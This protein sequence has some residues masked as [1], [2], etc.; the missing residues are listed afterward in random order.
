MYASTGTS[1]QPGQLSHADPA[2]KPGQSG[3][4]EC[5]HGEFPQQDNGYD[6]AVF[7]LSGLRHQI[8]NEANTEF[9]SWNWDL[10]TDQNSRCLTRREQLFQ[11]LLAGKLLFENK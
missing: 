11:E 10:A 9:P 5:C 1:L 6:C 4:W 3:P 8:V 7:M 2:K